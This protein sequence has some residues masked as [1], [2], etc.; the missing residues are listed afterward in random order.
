MAQGI[1]GRK[2][3]IK[4]LRLIV[5]AARNVLPQRTDPFSTSRRAEGGDAEGLGSEQDPC[6]P[7]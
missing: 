3:Q 7:A 6:S 2:V 4:S 5:A 1:K